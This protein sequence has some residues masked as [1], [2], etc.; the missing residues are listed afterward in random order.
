MRL[1]SR[2]AAGGSTALL[3]IGDIVALVAF[4]V[5]GLANHDR[6]NNL[7]ADVASIGAPFLIGWLVVAA[8]VGAFRATGGARS[9]LL[10]SV[11]AWALGIGLALVLRN[12]VFGHT[13]SPVFA[14][15][16]YVFN[17]IFLL[18]WRAVFSRL[19]LW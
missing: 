18:G 14:V 13:F 16:A 8:L 3:L 1:Q 15:I 11:L 19:F 10:R 6:T 2:S 4:I 9:F 7:V 17:G 12:T 5:V